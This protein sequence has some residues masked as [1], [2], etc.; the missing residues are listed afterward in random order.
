MT[1]RA[2]VTVVGVGLVLFLL[3]TVGASAQ[4]KDP[5]L[6]TWKQNVEQSRCIIP[7]T[8][9]PCDP[10]PRV[11]TT[12]VFEDL[13]SGFV[14]ASNDGVDAEGTATG[15]RVIFKR[16]GKDYPLAAPAQPGFVTIAFTTVS[17]SPFDSEFV[18]KLDGEVLSRST[19]TL[20]RDGKTYT[21]VT[22]GTNVR[23]Q[24]VFSTIV[25]DKVTSSK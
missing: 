10:P 7:V 8:G 21:T 19:E 2:S 24:T 15:N 12:R 11:P 4:S 18:I 3:S 23:G 17:S 13:G 25:F 16:D 6:G 14:F 22:R 9:N 5:L 1:G 20:S